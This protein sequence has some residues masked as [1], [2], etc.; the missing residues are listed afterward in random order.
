MDGRTWQGSACV[1]FKWNRLLLGNA[2]ISLLGYKYV[3]FSSMCMSLLGGC[4]GIFSAFP[5]VASGASQRPL[6]S[7]E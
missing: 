4:V 7:R 1:E 3:G 5:E 6:G 2:M